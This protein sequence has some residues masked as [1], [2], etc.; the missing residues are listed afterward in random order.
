MKRL[1]LILVIAGLILVSFIASANVSAVEPATQTVTVIVA[2]LNVRRVPESRS[3]LITVLSKD[4][5]VDAQGRDR[6]GTWVKVKTSNGLGWVRTAYVITSGQLLA[7]PIVAIP[8]F[9]IINANPVASVRLGPFPA[10]PV[11]KQLP[12]LTDV[13]VIGLHSKN[14]AIEIKT[15]D[16]VTGWV[17]KDLVTVGGNVDVVPDTDRQAPPAAKINAYR[18]KVRAAPDATADVVTTVQ[19]GQYYLIIGTDQ[20]TRWIKIAI[21]G[22]GAGW[23]PAR[24]ATIIGYTAFTPVLTEN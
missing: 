7:L 3:T 11:V 8:A 23:M 6:T 1:A 15:L 2:Q 17:D 13:D 9:G 16:G 19:L 4:D 5:R 18:V 14:T 10:Y 12:Y 21:P 20:T 24:L 22:G